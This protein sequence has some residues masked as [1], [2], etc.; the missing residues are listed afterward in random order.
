M[1]PFDSFVK[2]LIGV[3]PATQG[4]VAVATRIR[5]RLDVLGGPCPFPVVEAAV[6]LGQLEAGDQLAVTFDCSDA[7]VSL[8][9]WAAAQGHRVVETQADA[10]AW[11]IV[12]ERA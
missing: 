1:S 5:Y 10:G 12:L 4:G 2:P 9:A 7:L 8:P 11:T 3:S 6:A